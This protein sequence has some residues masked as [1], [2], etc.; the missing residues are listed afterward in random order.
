LNFHIISLVIL[1]IVDV[2]IVSHVSNKHNT[3]SA[4]GPKRTFFEIHGLKFNF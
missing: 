2:D 1:V 3:V 4:K